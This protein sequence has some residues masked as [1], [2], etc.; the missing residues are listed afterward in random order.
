M[1]RIAEIKHNDVANGDGVCVSVWFQGCPHHCKDCFNYE[2]WNFNDGV[3]FDNGHIEEVLESL[4]KNNIKR[5]L[6]LLGGDP[7]CEQ[8]IY[9]AIKLGRVVKCNNENIKIYVWTGYKFE[10]LKEKYGSCMF[11]DIDIIIDGEFE[12]EKK[13]LNL[14]LRGSSNQRIINVKETLKQN[15]IILYEV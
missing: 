10:Y 12:V 6:S 13:D 15:K 7:L 9:D 1:G 8:N 3:E 4:N 2:T 5:N 14:K 11:K